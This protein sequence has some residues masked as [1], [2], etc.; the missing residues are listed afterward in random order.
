MGHAEPTLFLPP[1]DPLTPRELGERYAPRRRIE[2]ARAETVDVFPVE[3][4]TSA[5]AL[6][7]ELEGMLTWIAKALYRPV[8]RQLQGFATPHPKQLF[9]HVL[10][11]PAR[12]TVTDP[13]VTVQLHRRAHHPLRVARKRL[14]A[15]PAVPW[16]PGQSRYVVAGVGTPNSRR[17]R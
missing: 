2:T 12:L 13:H 9:R 1:E 8:A 6:Q 17:D 10:E 15:T 4:W 7:G 11:T 14:N 5:R 3:A 16:W